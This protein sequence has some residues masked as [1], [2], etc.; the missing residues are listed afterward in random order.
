MPSDDKASFDDV[1]LRV[2]GLAPTTDHEKLTAQLGSDLMASAEVEV[3]ATS[4]PTELAAN[5]PAAD[6]TTDPKEAGGKESADKS[7]NDKTKPAKS[8]LASSG[9][10]AVGKQTG[11]G[12]T[13]L[14]GNGRGGVG[15][16]TGGGRTGY[17]S[18]GLDGSYGTVGRGIARGGHNIGVG[19]STYSGYRPGDT[20]IHTGTDTDVVHGDTTHTGT[21]GTGVVGTGTVRTGTIDT[22]NG[23][24]VVAPGTVV[25][26]RAEVIDVKP[27]VSLAVQEVRLLELQPVGITRSSFASSFKITVTDTGDYRIIDVKGNPLNDWT[28][29]DGGATVTLN[30][31]AIPRTVNDEYELY[32]ERKIGLSVKRFQMP[33]KLR[34]DK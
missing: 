3:L 31:L 9:K 28:R 6:G 1:T 8:G 4:Q 20:V 10:P 17:G 26:D 22:T 33:F 32:V 14:A 12:G 24:T 23:T 29:I 2:A 19:H 11:K 16:G 7:K 18:Y 21:V 5:T 27:D 25:G 34:A 13:G 15:D 30:V